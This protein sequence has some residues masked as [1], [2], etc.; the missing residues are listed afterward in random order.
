VIERFHM[1]EG[2]GMPEVDV[3]AG[4]LLATP[5][6]RGKVMVSFW[7]NPLYPIVKIQV[8]KIQVARVPMARIAEDRLCRMSSLLTVSYR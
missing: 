8:A 4:R 3:R 1:I 6:N 2:G 5:Q 7:R